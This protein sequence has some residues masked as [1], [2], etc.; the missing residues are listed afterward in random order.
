MQHGKKAG[1]ATDNIGY[2]FRQIDSI[3]AKI[4][5]FRKQYGQWYHNNYLSQQGKENRLFGF[6]QGNKSGLSGK[7]KSHKEKTK[8]IVFQCLSTRN[9]QDPTIWMLI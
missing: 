4:P 1:E 3:Y 6:P 9:Q 7:L 8:K 5:H 2:R